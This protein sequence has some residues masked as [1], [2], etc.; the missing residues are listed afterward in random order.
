MFFPSVELLP[1][2]IRSNASRK[3]NYFYNYLSFQEKIKKLS[4]K[5]KYSAGRN[6]TGK[7]VLWTKK[8]ITRIFKTPLINFNL[9]YNK[10]AFVASFQFLQYNNKL[11]A[12][13]FFSNGVISYY[14]AVN[15]FTLFDFYYWNFNKKTRNFFYNKSWSI[16]IFLKKLIFVSF[17]EIKPGRGAQYVLSSGT[18]AKL[19][20]INYNF[21]SVTL[22]LPS[23]IKKIFSLYSATLMSENMLLEKK[24]YHNTKSG[25]WRSLGKK[26]IVR[27]VAMNPVDHPHGGRTKAIRHQRTPWGKT[28]KIK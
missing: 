13:F 1:L 3:I 10:L 19:F 24:Y 7:I 5:K 22:Q 17:V 14:N 4:L 12:L 8:K 16:F 9:R 25:Y 21:K 20:S 27:G 26:S 23:K 15:N 28:T 6:D 11:V 2:S 18:K